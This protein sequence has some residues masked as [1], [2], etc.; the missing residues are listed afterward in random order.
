[1]EIGPFTVES[2]PT[3]KELVHFLCGV[4]VEECTGTGELHEP[5]ESMQ[6][7]LRTRDVLS[8]DESQFDAEEA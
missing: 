8:R 2:H 4:R 1:M 7:Y 5:E 6:E 3:P